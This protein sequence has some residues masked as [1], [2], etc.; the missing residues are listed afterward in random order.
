MRKNLMKRKF[1]AYDPDSGTILKLKEYSQISKNG[2][3]KTYLIDKNNN[4]VFN[5]NL[6]K[7]FETEQY[8]NNMIIEISKKSY[9]LISEF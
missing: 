4:A 2:V 5:P 1:I 8:S 3:R 9:Y 6:N 7:L